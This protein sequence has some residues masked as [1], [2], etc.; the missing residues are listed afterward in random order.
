M[1]KRFK[2]ELE[3]SEQKYQDLKE[4]HD[5]E[6]HDLFQNAGTLKFV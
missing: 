4:T 1:Q 2:K 5:K 6:V 3:L